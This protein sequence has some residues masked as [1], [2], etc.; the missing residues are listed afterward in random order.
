[1]DDYGIK[2]EWREAWKWADLLPLGD[3]SEWMA[4]ADLALHLLAGWMESE[5]RREHIHCKPQQIVMLNPDRKFIEWYN[6]NDSCHDPR[7]KYQYADWLAEARKE[8]SRCQ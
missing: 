6:G 4:C 7:H 2:P 3:S 8:L 1:M 5:F